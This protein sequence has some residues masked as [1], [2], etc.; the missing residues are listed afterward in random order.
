LLFLCL[1]EHPGRRPG[2][3]LSCSGCTGLT[4]VTVQAATPPALPSGSAAFNGCAAGLQIHVPAGTVAAYQAAAGW[5]D[6]AAKIVS[7]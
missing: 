5:I 4:S 3:Q 2:K 7:P 6:Y 1:L